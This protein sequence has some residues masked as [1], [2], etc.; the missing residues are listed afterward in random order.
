MLLHQL[1]AGFLLV[2][3]TLRLQSAGIAV[4]VA[5]MKHAAEGD[6]HKNGPSTRI[7]AGREIHDRGGPSAWLG[8]SAV[9]D[10][11]SV[12]LITLLGLSVL[13]LGEQLFN[14]WLQRSNSASRFATFWAL[15]EQ[16]WRVDMQNIR[17]PSLRDN[18]AAHQ[19]RCALI[20]QTAEAM[21]YGCSLGVEGLLMQ[22]SPEPRTHSQCRD[23]PR[24]SP[25]GSR[26][27]WAVGGDDVATIVEICVS[28]LIVLACALAYIILVGL[29]I[30]LASD[31]AHIC[32]HV[33]TY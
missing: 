3:S 1:G 28:L 30:V 33:P 4:L 31:L 26:W 9:G 7:C 29:V 6:I 24:N 23:S 19:S 12:E 18:N 11:Q 2:T 5:W 32:R 27:H 25:L 8:D 21:Y 16:Q 13:L 10:P 15:G 17:K 22:E 14:C 20:A